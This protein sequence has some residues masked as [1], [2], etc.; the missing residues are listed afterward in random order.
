M[1]R[2]CWQCDEL[3]G[4]AVDVG[5]AV[6]DVPADAVNATTGTGQNLGWFGAID[7]GLDPRSPGEWADPE[8]APGGLSGFFNG[9]TGA[10]TALAG[11]VGELTADPA[12]A[13]FGLDPAHGQQNDSGQE[14]PAT[15]ENGQLIL[16][17]AIGLVVA[18]IVFRRDA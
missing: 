4:G 13:F 15:D 8:E 3:L 5:E 17:F 16:I 2:L 6:V 9:A 18:W 11:D 12:L 14:E 1:G 10:T 7:R